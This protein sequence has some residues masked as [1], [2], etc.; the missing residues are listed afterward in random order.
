M[1]Q[2][3]DTVGLTILRLLLTGDSPRISR[4][5]VSAAHPVA[6]LFAAGGHIAEGRI[7]RVQGLDAGFKVSRRL[8]NSASSAFR[9]FRSAVISLRFQFARE[10][11]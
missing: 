5:S 8:S 9:R 3:E 10:A 1:A 6:G 11:A 4:I 7:R 2:C